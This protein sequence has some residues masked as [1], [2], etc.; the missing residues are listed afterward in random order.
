MS[1][2]IR[3][4]SPGLKLRSVRERLRLTYR[5]VEDA[6]VR[7]AVRRGDDQFQIGLSR[8]A[9]IEHRGT[10]PSIYRLYSLAVIYRLDFKTVLRW[11][12]IDLGSQAVDAAAVTLPGTNML[13]ATVAEEVQLPDPILGMESADMT[14]TFYFSRLAQNWG[15][16][17]AAL[18]RNLDLIRYRYAFIGV[19]DY[20]MNPMIRPGS[21]VQIDEGR[22]KIAVDGWTNEWDRP[23]YLVEWREGLRCAWCSLRGSELV[24]QPH[25]ASRES[26]QTFRMPGEVD[27][28]G[29]VVGVAMRIH[30]GRVPHARS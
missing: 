15:K 7:V 10:L 6:S 5:D 4:Q 25:P 19:D 14:K 30:V 3:L 13:D 11:Y 9:D 29:Q 22:T 20:F 23:I 16:L 17:P 2:Q 26:P 28:V 18:V 1:T 27:V 12:G 21:F 8:L 24:L